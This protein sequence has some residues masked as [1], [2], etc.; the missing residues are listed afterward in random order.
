MEGWREG[1]MEGRDG[2]EGGRDMMTIMKWVG[3]CGMECVHNR[4]PEQSRVTS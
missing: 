2:W 3:A 4:E 1:W